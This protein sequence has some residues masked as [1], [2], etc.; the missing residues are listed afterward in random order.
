MY[1]VKSKIK[2]KRQYYETLNSPSILP[3]PCS[4]SNT[5][6]ILNFKLPHNKQENILTILSILLENIMKS[7]KKCGTKL[8]ELN[9]YKLWSSNMWCKLVH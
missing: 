7:S 9:K 1:S 2:S 8:R 4:S 6:M 5:W 3:F